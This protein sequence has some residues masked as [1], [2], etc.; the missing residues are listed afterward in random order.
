M[1]N[2]KERILQLFM[3]KVYGHSP[4]LRSYN[5]RHAGAA[6][7]WLEKKLGKEPDASN[8]SDFWGYE[9]KNHTTSGKTTWGDWSANEYIFDKGNKYNLNRNSFFKFFGKPN[10]KKKIDT[11]GQENQSLQFLIKFLVLDN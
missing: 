10:I 7:H 11:L 5:S 6:G 1:D 9:C 4:V 2:G 8:E 3:Q